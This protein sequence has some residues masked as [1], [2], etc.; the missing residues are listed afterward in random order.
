V[1]A[2]VSDNGTVVIRALALK[3]ISSFKIDII[4]YRMGAKLFQESYIQQGLPP[5]CVIV[6]DNGTVVIRAFA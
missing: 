6:S 2:I 3:Q 1:W 4:F 5:P